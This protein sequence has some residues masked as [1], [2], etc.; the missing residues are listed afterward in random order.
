MLIKV[1]HG[2]VICP[3]RWQFDGEI[4]MVQPLRSAC[5][6]ML[7]MAAMSFRPLANQSVQLPAWG[8]LV[9]FC[10]HYTLNAPLLSCGHGRDGWIEAFLN[11]RL[12]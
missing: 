12:L 5:E 6:V 3:C 1:A 9:V 10:S 8:F 11:A 7:M 2:K 4:L